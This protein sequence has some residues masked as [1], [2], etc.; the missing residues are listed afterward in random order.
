MT[1][2]KADTMHDAIIPPVNAH[3]PPSIIGQLMQ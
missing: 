1:Y 2:L 3:Q